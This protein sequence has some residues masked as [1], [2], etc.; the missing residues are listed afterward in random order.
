MV[1]VS[2]QPQLSVLALLQE[3]W[4]CLLGSLFSIW[5]RHTAVSIKV[6]YRY[7]YDRCMH[8]VAAFVRACFPRP[9]RG[10]SPSHH[11]RVK[12][13]SAHAQPRSDSLQRCLPSVRGAQALSSGASATR[14]RRSDARCLRQ[15]L[16]AIDL[17]ATAGPNDGGE[18]RSLAGPS[19][20]D[21]SWPLVFY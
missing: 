5:Y 12:R 8:T 1:A 19:R 2:L 4:R 9:L 7:R 10:Q 14:W 11:L 15:A 16:R 21:A 17:R 18:A 3:R 13:F 6:L 20:A